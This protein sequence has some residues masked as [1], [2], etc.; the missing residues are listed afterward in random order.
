M[1]SGRKSKSQSR[2]H[3]DTLIG[4]GTRIVG[5]VIF[6][7]GLRLDGEIQGNVCAAEG[8]D[9]LLIVSEQAR[10]EGNVDVARMIVNGVINGEVRSAD[11]LELHPNARLTGDVRYNTIEIQ[12]GAVLRG[13]LDCLAA[14]G[15]VT[16][17]KLASGQ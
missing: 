2:N 13:Q 17:L 4:R 1:F 5:D 12:L 16:E 14:S 10:I 8:Q 6:S 11:F 15:Q 7:G 3:I 9:C